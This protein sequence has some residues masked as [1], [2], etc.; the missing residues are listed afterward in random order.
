MNAVDIPGDQLIHLLLSILVGVGFGFAF[1]ESPN[2]GLMKPSGF[3][4]QH[5]P[6]VIDEN[7]AVCSFHPVMNYCLTGSIDRVGW[8][9]EIIYELRE[10]EESCPGFEGQRLRWLVTAGDNLTEFKLSKNR[11][12]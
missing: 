11:G 10:Q 2:A 4:Q 3:P 9:R 1:G 6:R 5:T 7:S 12:D 8:S